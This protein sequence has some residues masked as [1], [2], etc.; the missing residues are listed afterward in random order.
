[1]KILFLMLGTLQISREIKHY[2]INGSVTW[3]TFEKYVGK[4]ATLSII[5]QVSKHGLKCLLFL[6]M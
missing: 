5:Y 3:L 4:R 6:K 1:M 2:L